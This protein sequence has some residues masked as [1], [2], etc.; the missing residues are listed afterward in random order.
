MQHA[1]CNHDGYGGLG[2]AIRTI[3][4]VGGSQ[5]PRGISVGFGKALRMM[6]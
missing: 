3:P 4:K 2:R 6:M 1:I 5:C